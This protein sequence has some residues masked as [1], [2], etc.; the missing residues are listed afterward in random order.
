[1][2]LAANMFKSQFERAQKVNVGEE[3]PEIP[4][5]DKEEAKEKKEAEPEKKD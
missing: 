2:Y 5:E 3:V 4:Y 1:M